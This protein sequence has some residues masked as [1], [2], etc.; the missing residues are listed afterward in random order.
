VVSITMFISI[1]FCEMVFH[2]CHEVMLKIYMFF[3]F[4]LDVCVCEHCCRFELEDFE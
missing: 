3:N 2:D 4:I 1:L